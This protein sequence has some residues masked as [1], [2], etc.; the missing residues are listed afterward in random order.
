MLFYRPDTPKSALPA[1]SSTSL[2]G[3]LLPHL[4]W[5]HLVNTYEG[6]AG[7]VLFEGKIV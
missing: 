5:R 6:K 2:H 4:W 1:G 3:C 7:M